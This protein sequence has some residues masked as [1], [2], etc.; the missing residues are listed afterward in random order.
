MFVFSSGG[1]IRGCGILLFGSDICSLF[2]FRALSIVNGDCDV[3]S[4]SDV[5]DSYCRG[6]N[7]LDDPL[8][9]FAS[10]RFIAIPHGCHPCVRGI[11]SVYPVDNGP[12][13]GASKAIGEELGN[14]DSALR[15]VMHLVM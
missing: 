8:G 12:G 15:V 14:S 13:N 2:F 5:R 11:G 10:C 1:L 4:S 7:A 6:A 3:A 9:T